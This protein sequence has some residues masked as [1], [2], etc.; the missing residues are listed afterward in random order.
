V[1]FQSN[2]QKSKAKEE[3]EKMENCIDVQKTRRRVEDHLRKNVNPE[4][5][6]HLA[7]NLGVE[8]AYI[9]AP[10][11]PELEWEIVR[12][13][14]SGETLPAE[15]IDALPKKYTTYYVGSLHP[16]ADGSFLRHSLNHLT[17]EGAE[18]EKKNESHRI[19]EEKLNILDMRALVKHKEG[20]CPE[21]DKKMLKKMKR[22]VFEK[23]EII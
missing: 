18:S 3:K 9:S 13:L 11:P 2:A 19:V 4:E 23:D 21:E 5:L 8:V 10:E 1:F 16:L 12:T 20:W 17:R 22:L 14:R 6:V 7:Q 15:I